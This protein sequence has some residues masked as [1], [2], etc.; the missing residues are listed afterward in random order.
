MKVIRMLV[1]SALPNFRGQSG[2]VQVDSDGADALIAAQ[3]AERL[4]TDDVVMQRAYLADAAAALGVTIE[5]ADADVVAA[6]EAFGAHVVK[7][8]RSRGH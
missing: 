3:Q 4:S 2:I 5:S 6:A 8:R 1:G 7:P